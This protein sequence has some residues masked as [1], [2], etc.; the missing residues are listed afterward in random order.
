[1]TTRG[2][3]QTPVAEKIA[4]LRGEEAA[5][6]APLPWDH[7]NPFD[8]QD[9]KEA[10]WCWDWVVN[11]CQ[12]RGVLWNGLRNLVFE[13]SV[14]YQRAIFA[15]LD[16]SDMITSMDDMGVSRAHPAIQV[17]NSSFDR[18]RKCGERLG[19]DPITMNKPLLATTELGIAEGT[20]PAVIDLMAFARD[21]NK[22]PAWERDSPDEGG[23]A[24]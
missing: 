18:M 22:P 15:G 24:S 8:P 12:A 20:N 9:Q 17:E 14:M 23:K 11:D 6:P 13:Y 16:R 10:H 4:R 19:L 7:P 2:R 1:M 3:P 5:R 21:R